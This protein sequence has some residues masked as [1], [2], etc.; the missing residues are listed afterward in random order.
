MELG[1]PEL[2]LLML[3]VIL[4][5]GV[6]RIGK[7]ASELGSGVKAFKDGLRGDEPKPYPA[8]VNEQFGVQVSAL[9]YQQLFLPNEL[10]PSI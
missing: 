8:Q 6:G 3:I 4:L 10:G 5:F 1:V 9:E 7:I 2:L